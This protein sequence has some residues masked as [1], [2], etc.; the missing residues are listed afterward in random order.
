M[1]TVES[2]MFS[3]VHPFFDPRGRIFSLGDRGNPETY[4]HHPSLQRLLAQECYR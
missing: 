3:L 4:H 2:L 1:M